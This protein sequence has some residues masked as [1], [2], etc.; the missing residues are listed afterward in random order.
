MKVPCH[1]P[2]TWQRL[3]MIISCIRKSRLNR[4][5]S[6]LGADQ[7]KNG[8]ALPRSRASTVQG[9]VLAPVLRAAS[10]SCGIVFAFCLAN[11]ERERGVTVLAIPVVAQV[12]GDF[13]C[14]KREYEVGEKQR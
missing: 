12:Y 4:R 2:V 7:Q 9:K 10:G 6:R 1:N 11:A 3:I 5:R 14:P 8:H 13:A